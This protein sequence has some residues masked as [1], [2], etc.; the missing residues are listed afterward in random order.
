MPGLRFICGAIVATIAALNSMP[1][2]V[3]AGVPLERE[4]KAAYLYKFVPFVTWPASAF[5]SPTA[6]LTI[7]IVGEQGFAESLQPAV[8]GQRQGDHPIAV[9]ATNTP[10]AQC[11]I[12][13]LPG[14][15]SAADAQ[16][17]AAL[18]NR[19]VLIVTDLPADVAGHGMI[20][21]VV[22][23]D[24]V[25]FDIDNAAATDCGLVISSKLLGLARVVKSRGTP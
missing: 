8:A 25:R 22:T 5:A 18:K 9:R 10:D 23:G 13:Y 24:R 6:P 11:H 14:N 2:A 20:G 17:V 15:D 12:L 7:C 4:I 21:F 19:P 1:P 3:A 16:I